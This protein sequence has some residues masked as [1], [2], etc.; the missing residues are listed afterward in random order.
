MD[1]AEKNE[2]K[3]RRQMRTTSKI[4]LGF[5]LAILTGGVLLL[6]CTLAGVG[7]FD[8]DQH[9]FGSDPQQ[10]ADGRVV[11]PGRVLQP[12][13]QVRGHSHGQDWFAISL[14]RLRCHIITSFLWYHV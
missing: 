5:L 10:V 1:V 3:L 13:D 2:K 9:L 12:L 7:I 6:R 4:L 14:L 11:A 8:A